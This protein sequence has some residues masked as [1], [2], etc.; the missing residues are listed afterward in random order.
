[1]SMKFLVNRVSQ[2]PVSKS[3]PCCGAVRGPESPVWPGEYQWYVEMATLED[4]VRFLDQNGGGL[5]LFTPEEGEE[6]PVIEVL[7]EEEDDA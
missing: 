7:D 4:L 5:G 6:Y 3:P 2:G 1:M